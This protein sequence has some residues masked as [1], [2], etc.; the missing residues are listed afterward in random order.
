MGIDKKQENILL[1]DIKRI[2]LGVSLIA[3]ESSKQKREYLANLVDEEIKRIIEDVQDIMTNGT[4]KPTKSKRYL[5]NR[6]H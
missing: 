6:R 2:S 3:G 4:N 5:R 1:H